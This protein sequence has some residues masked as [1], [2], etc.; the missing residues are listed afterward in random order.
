MSTIMLSHCSSKVTLLC[1]KVIL[2][3]LVESLARS[4]R[5]RHPID[6]SASTNALLNYGQRWRRGNGVNLCVN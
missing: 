2:P 1:S 6:R 5:L 4:S 3:R